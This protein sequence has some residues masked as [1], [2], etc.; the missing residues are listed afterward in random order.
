MALT[1]R[2]TAGNGGERVRGS[3]ARAGGVGGVQQQ[4]PGG[5][6]QRQQHRGLFQHPRNESEHAQ[7]EAL[8]LPQTKTLE[9]SKVETVNFEP[10]IRGRRPPATSHLTVRE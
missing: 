6:G 1:D 7:N 9:G 3:D 5:L 8:E 4:G 10:E 2:S